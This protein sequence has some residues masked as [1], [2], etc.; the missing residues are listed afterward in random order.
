MTREH[1]SQM[2]R[3]EEDDDD[4]KERE[5]EGEENSLDNV[6]VVEREISKSQLLCSLSQVLK[7]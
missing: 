1:S 2:M 7:Q 5:R 4:E 6:K 3:E